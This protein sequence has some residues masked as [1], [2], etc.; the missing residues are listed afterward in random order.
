MDGRLAADWSTTAAHTTA[1]RSRLIK[2]SFHREVFGRCNPTRS[3]WRCSVELCVHV[4][5]C[6]SGSSRDAIN[7]RCG[8]DPDRDGCVLRT[9]DRW[10]WAWLSAASSGWRTALVIV[11]PETVI[12]WH[13]LGVRLFSITSSSA[14]SA[15]GVGCWFERRPRWPSA[16]RTAAFAQS[17]SNGLSRGLLRG[18]PWIVLAPRPMNCVALLSGTGSEQRD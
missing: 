1:I 4:P 5:R 12:A 8:N 9:P 15:D 6:T 17:P 14:T 7:C 13:R 3:G 18:L 16:T 10:L 11:K 2:G